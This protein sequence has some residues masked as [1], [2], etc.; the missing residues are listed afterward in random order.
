MRA[1][2]DG[3]TGDVVGSFLAERRGRDYENFFGPPGGGAAGWHRQ[4]LTDPPL[5]SL[6]WRDGGGVR[7]RQCAAS[8]PAAGQD[9]LGTLGVP[10]ALR[11]ALALTASVP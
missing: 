9:P 4:L 10:S 2:A 7:T 8:L 6:R 1:G 5:P 3:K 11:Q